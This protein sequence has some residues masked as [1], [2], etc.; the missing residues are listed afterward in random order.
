MRRREIVS[1]IG[2]IAVCLLAAAARAQQPA[3]L[4]S[5]SPEEAA[6]HLQAFREG[7]KEVGYVEAARPVAAPRGPGGADCRRSKPGPRYSL[8]GSPPPGGGEVE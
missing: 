1:L 2:A 5:R 6:H 3:L 7:L 4:S 8:Q